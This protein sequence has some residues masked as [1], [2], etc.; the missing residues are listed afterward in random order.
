VTKADITQWGGLIVAGLTTLTAIWNRLSIKRLDMK[1]D[2][3]LQWRSRAD[4]AE[5]KLEEKDD[6]RDRAQKEHSK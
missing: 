1:T 6:V 5:A 4:R 3:L 2:G